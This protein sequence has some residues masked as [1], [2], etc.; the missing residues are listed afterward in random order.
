MTSFFFDNVHHLLKQLQPSPFAAT[1]EQKASVRVFSTILHFFRRY[2]GVTL[3]SP[4][5]LATILLAS[6]NSL[7]FSQLD[8]VN[9]SKTISTIPTCSMWSSNARSKST[10]DNRL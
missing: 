3:N 4:Q 8:R 2:R 7:M 9:L 1:M 6:N 5:L 10:F